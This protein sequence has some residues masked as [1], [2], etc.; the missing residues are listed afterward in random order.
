MSLCQPYCRRLAADLNALKPEF[1]KAGAKLTIVSG[2]DKGAQEFVDAVWPNGNIYVDE[3]E[4]FKKAIHGGEGVK[5]KNWW[6]L[7]P[8]VLKNIIS[9]AKNFGTSTADTMDAKTQ[10]L[11]GTF[12]VRDN[13]VIYAHKETTSFDNGS[14]KEMLAAVLGKS[15]SEIDVATT[16]SQVEEVCNRK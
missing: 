4:V 8:S 11:G 5:Y 14:A 13:K 2:Q 1:D 16:P 3:E 9:Y 15:A 7:R 10:L 12:I 6:L